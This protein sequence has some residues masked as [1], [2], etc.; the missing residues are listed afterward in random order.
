ML[1]TKIFLDNE[2]V[3]FA[4]PLPRTLYDLLYFLTD[5]LKALGKTMASI[6][7]DDLT[8]VLEENL[9]QPLHVF[10]R[11]QIASETDVLSPSR[12]T[13]V[14]LLRDAQHKLSDLQGLLLIGDFGQVLDHSKTLAEIIQCTIKNLDSLKL[15]GVPEVND[16]CDRF[17]FGY[18]KILSD[19]MHLVE[20]RDIGCLYEVIQHELLPL[21]RETDVQFT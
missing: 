5:H 8:E 18:H 12:N 7:V 21:I 15:A 1:N 16:L 3:Q 14:E 19:W 9:A 10:Q 4:G 11:I 17:S 20:K 2:E 6:Q 13:L